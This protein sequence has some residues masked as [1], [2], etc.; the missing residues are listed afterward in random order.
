MAHSPSQPRSRSCLPALV[1]LL[2]IFAAAAVGGQQYLARQRALAEPLSG[3]AKA[4]EVQS[5]ENLTQI[6]ERLTAAALL[7]DPGPFTRLAKQQGVARDIQAGWY[8]L[9]PATG[10]AGILKQLVGG[11]VATRKVT[12]PE[13]L[14]IDQAAARCEAAGIGAGGEYRRLATK[15][16]AS[17]GLEGLPAGASLEGYLFPATYR[18]PLDAGPRELIRAQVNRFVQAWKEA[19]DGAPETVHS[20]HEIV[21]IAS[22]IEEEVKQDEERAKVAGVIENRLRRGMKLEFCSTVLYALGEHKERLLYRDLKVKSPYNT[23]LHKG[24][25]PGPIASPGQASLNAALRP[26]Q[27]DD[28]YFVLT[29]D[30]QHHFSKTATEHISAKLAGERARSR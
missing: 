16:A 26:A 24:L 12:F 5:G 27:H 21:T 22:L 11:D 23:Y 19:L 7:R 1:L 14:T 18:L 28:L 9:D 4:F 2:V 20:R 29:A 15:D 13:G 10:P 6:A 8:E 3:P 17:F 25:P 30:G